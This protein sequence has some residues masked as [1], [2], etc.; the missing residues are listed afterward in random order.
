MQTRLNDALPLAL[1]L[2]QNPTG[3]SLFNMS[4]SGMNPA[5]VLS[6]LNSVTGS[7]YGSMTFGFIPTRPGP[8]PGTVTYTNA[9]TVATNPQYNVVNLVGLSEHHY[10]QRSEFSLQHRNGLR[11]GDHAIARVK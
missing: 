11:S 3:A 5:T 1:R 10:Q 4:G 6:G 7:Q 9:N 8:R 2:L